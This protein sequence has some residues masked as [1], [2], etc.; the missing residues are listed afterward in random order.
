MVSNRAIARSLFSKGNLPPMKL[1]LSALHW[2]TRMLLRMSIGF[3]S[4]HYV[5]H[6]SPWHWYQKIDAI[7]HSIGLIL[8]SPHDPCFY[9]GFVHHAWNPL[10][11][12][13]SFPLSMD[14][15]DNN[16]VN[17]SAVEMLYER[18]LKECI[19]VYF[20]GLMEWFLGIHF[21]RCFTKS[22]IVVHFNQSGYVANQV[23]Q[24]CRDSWEMAPTATPYW[25]GIPIN[26]I[27]PST[28][29]ENSLAQL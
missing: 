11:P 6:C 29:E 18:L 23:K 20:M 22:E 2:E 26:S 15:Y 25:S 9:T 27:A 10:E 14:L 19:K 24:F 8:P 17:L 16:F 28:D 4:W 21:L 5:I 13:P 12:S 1:H 3:S 7:L